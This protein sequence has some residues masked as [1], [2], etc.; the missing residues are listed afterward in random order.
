MAE[1]L[2]EFG[3]DLLIRVFVAIPC[4]LVGCDSVD[5]HKILHHLEMARRTIV[6]H[7][8]FFITSNCCRILA[9]SFCI[10]FK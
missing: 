4:P 8:N 7:R 9:N 3:A 6:N 5:A 2:A 10:E 1:S